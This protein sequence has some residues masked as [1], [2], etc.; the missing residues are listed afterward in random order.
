MI[1]T[2]PAVGV[3]REPT[4]LPNQTANRGV[5]YTRPRVLPFNLALYFENEIAQNDSNSPTVY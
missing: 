5:Y 2:Q 3:Y 1:R 4:V